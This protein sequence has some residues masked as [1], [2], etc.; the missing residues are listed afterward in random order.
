MARTVTIGNKMALGFAAVMTLT[1]VIGAA[2]LIGLDRLE[3]HSTLQDERLANAARVQ[4]LPKLALERYQNQ[5]DLILNGKLQT[6]ESYA[7]ATR[8]F[9]ALDAELDQIVETPEEKAWM[10]KLDQACCDYTKLFNEHLVPEVKHELSKLLT[11][12]D[13]KSDT[14]IKTI[15]E[16]TRKLEA[17]LHADLDKI[18][19]AK[20]MLHSLSKQYQSQADFIINQQTDAIKE[21]D[22][23]VVVMDAS[24]EIVAPAID[25]EEERV[26][27]AKINEDDMQYDFLLGDEMVAVP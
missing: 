6:I 23:S 20:D 25:T 2:S 4:Q 22:V 9:E 11:Q 13:E 26:L 3:V 14:L 17:K 10:E 16:A 18:V 27:I 5:A 1:I 24:K 12:Y 21:C 19:A 7:S 8:E 15:E